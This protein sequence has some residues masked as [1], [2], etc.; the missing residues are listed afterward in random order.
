MI[1]YKMCIGLAGVIQEFY[2]SFISNN[3]HM[4]V[5]GIILIVVG[6]LA[7]AYN[8]LIA[9][10]F[11]YP[12]T[13]DAAYDTGYAIGLF[14]IGIVGL[15]LLIIGIVLF[16]KAERRERQRQAKYY[17]YQSERRNQRTY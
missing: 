9:P 1:Y 7:M 11:E 6:I 2:S 5:T 3:K 14:A 13:G 15:L 17:D 4:K 16:R 8:G 12:H 10:S